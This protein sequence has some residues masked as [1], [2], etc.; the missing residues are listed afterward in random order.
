MTD[1]PSKKNLLLEHDELCFS[2]EMSASFYLNSDSVVDGE[3][4]EE[5]GSGAGTGTVTLSVEQL[6]AYL[7]ALFNKERRQRIDGQRKFAVCPLSE[8]PNNLLGKRKSQSG[9]F[10]ESPQI[11]PL[12]AHSQQFSGDDPSISANPVENSEAKERFPEKR[13]ENQLRLQKNLGLG[14]SK[15][16][17]LVR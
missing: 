2:P 6:S 7:Q 15:S 14:A 13:L 10:G 4:D 9:G 3:D 11:H 8:D 12:L 17:T 5:S 16:V 1:N